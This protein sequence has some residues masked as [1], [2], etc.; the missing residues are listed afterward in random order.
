MAVFLDSSPLSRIVDHSAETRGLT[1]ELK[2]GFLILGGYEQE[3]VQP[4][5]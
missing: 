3:F 5:Q 4:R 1:D 2:L